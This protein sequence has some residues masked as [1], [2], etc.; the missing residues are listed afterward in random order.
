MKSYDVRKEMM[1]AKY[2]LGLFNT[3]LKKQQNK[4]DNWKAN[5]KA[6]AEKAGLK[7]FSYDE[8]YNDY[9]VG[10]IDEKTFWRQ[11]K[12]YNL[13]IADNW[14][15]AD[16]L[17]WLQVN[18]ERYG[19]KYEALERLYE[20]TKRKEKKKANRKYAN[21]INGYRKRTYDPTRNRSKY[22]QPKIKKQGG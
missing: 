5:Q 12:M 21:K 9:I 6:R 1:V 22:N 20:E 7:Y 13:I 4:Y 17:K 14:Q 16:K 8:L 10:A 2:Q 11:R 19:R 18:V 3:E 15:R